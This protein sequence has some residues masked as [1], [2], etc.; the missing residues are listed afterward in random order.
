MSLSTA[1][2]LLLY[3]KTAKSGII[4]LFAI[5]LSVMEAYAYF[6]LFVTSCMEVNSQRRR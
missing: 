5:K 6:Q 1:R 3:R 4:C 2:D